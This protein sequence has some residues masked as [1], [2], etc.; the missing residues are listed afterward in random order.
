[1]ATATTSC[2]YP[3]DALEKDYGKMDKV[4]LFADQFIDIML[5]HRQ[6]G[7]PGGSRSKAHMMV[8]LM[9]SGV[10][11]W[12]VRQ[13][14]KPLADR[15]VLVAGHT[16]PLVYACL[17]IT[18]Y[19]MQLRYEWTKDERFKIGG[20]PERILLPMDLLT[21]RRGG[22]LPGHAEFEGKTLFV[23]FNTG[24]SGHG[25]P[26][27]AGQALALKHA[28]CE[29]VKVFAIE[30]EGGHSAGTHHET[31]NAAYG[32][33]LNNL[34][35]IL[36]WND[37]GIDPTAHSRVVYGTPKLWFESHGFRVRG[38][39]A[40]SD[41]A[42]V[43]PAL[44]DGA[45]G[46]NAEKAPRAV[47]FKTIKGRGYGVTGNDSHGAPHKRNSELF[48]ETKREFME[49]YE[50]EFEGFGEGDP[51][52]PAATEQTRSH[53][54]TV[55][56][57][58]AG[59]KALVEWLT[60]RL[61]EIGDSVPEKIEGSLVDMGKDLLAEDKTFSDYRNYPKEIYA[62]PGT[63]APNRK[64]FATFGGWLNKYAIEKY[65]RPLVLAMS[66]DLAG[67]TNISGLKEGS[68]WYD[69]DENPHGALLPQP[70]IEFSNAGISAGISTMNFAK[71]GEKKYAGYLSACST[72]GSFSYLK[73]GMM[74]LFSQ[75]AQDSEVKTGRVIWVAGHSG[76]ET[77]EDSRTHFGI[78]APGV[79][80]LFPQGQVINLHPWEHNEVAPALGAALASGVPL[81]ALHLTRPSV[82]IPDREKLGMPSYLEAGRGAYVLREYDQRPKQGV[83]LVQGTSV[84]SNTVGLLDWLAKDGPNVK[85]VCCVSYELFMLQD[86]AYRQS[87][88]SDAEWRDSMFAANQGLRICRDWIPARQMEEYAIT[89]DHDNRWRTGGSYEDIIAESHLDAAHLK[90]GVERYA[91]R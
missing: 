53:L 1:M 76:P 84:V 25:A 56:D 61:V 24:P 3:L 68:G 65:G 13:P 77:A 55:M 88:L 17:A 57:A 72:Y 90:Q 54:Q 10:M 20:G 45:C 70:I 66:A 47:W 60:D 8:A 73:Y 49:A 75:L 6:S 50:V 43:V 26:A 9:T 52:M 82:E 21:L 83:L 33:G 62:K 85:V 27:A 63:Q 71:D 58:L 29:E 74:R 80:Q 91:K 51:G 28:G 79:T 30:G 12:D 67:S 34:V 87:V 39:E 35:Y 40:G 46:E 31:K 42:S 4:R 69:R 2:P 86:E 36:D 14:T 11:R 22:G 38:T 37:Y 64:G 19:A 7:H 23:K 44:V 5:N 15:F 48:W 41:F 89:P 18:N 81:I 78:F 59:D 16:I 32:L